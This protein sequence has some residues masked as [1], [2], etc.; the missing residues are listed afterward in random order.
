MKRPHAEG[1][2]AEVMARAVEQ[3]VCADLGVDPGSVE[4]WAM[5][6]CLE[7]IKTGMPHTD[8]KTFA[9]LVR[10]AMDT[11][12][13]ADAVLALASAEVPAGRPRSW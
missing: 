3:I 7:A 2:M 10:Q 12:Q 13:A 4:S 6:S 11:R 1:L 8:P 9:T 5:V